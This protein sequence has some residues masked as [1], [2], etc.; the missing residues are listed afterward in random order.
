MQFIKKN[1]EKILLG[2]VL[3]GLI[4][5]LVFMMFYIS[6]DKLAME[7]MTG[8]IINAPVK[9]LPELDLTTNKMAVARLESPYVLDFESGN[10]MFNPFEW[11]RR[12]DGSLMK[13]PL[14]IAQAADVTGITPLYFILSLDGVTT[15]EFGARYL[16]VVERQAADKAS[17]RAKQRRYVSLGDKAND[18]FELIE[19][20]GLP[21]NPDALVVK[22]VDSG[23][24]ATITRAQPY[25]RLDAHMAD[26]RY[27][28][29]KK[30]FRARRNG[31]HVF[32]GGND[33]VVFEVNSNEVILSDQSNQKK[34]PLPFNP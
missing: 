8:G 25:R 6:A 17:K 22:L 32:F 10:K 19:V 24:T 13:K 23:E 3:A 28:L 31:D 11:I 20:K 34:T 2:I 15:N 4:G 7:E 1:Y 14:S 33:Y 21:E 16:V 30:T 5:G 12:P 9:P 26:L 27:E 29:E 18:A